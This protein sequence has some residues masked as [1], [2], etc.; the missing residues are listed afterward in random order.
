MRNF[1]K[2]YFSDLAL[3]SSDDEDYINE[4]KKD[5][6]SII[7]DIPIKD[8]YD[9]DISDD[10]TNI[11]QSCYNF[12][13]SK[14]NI[15]SKIIDYIH[16]KN[17]NN[18]AIDIIDGENLIGGPVIH[19]ASKV[20]RVFCKYL[21]DV[22]KIVIL[23]VKKSGGVKRFKNYTGIDVPNHFIFISLHADNGTCPDD[24]FILELAN[25]LSNVYVV[26]DDEY[27]DREN[28]NYGDIYNGTKLTTNI[29]INGRYYPDINTIN[30]T[31]VRRKGINKKNKQ[32][33]N[34]DIS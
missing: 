31:L 18:K 34:Y 20:K 11:D 24:G 2:C 32:I 26:T 12:D 23:V 13:Y 8:T 27:I 33:N 1:N 10:P 5:N 4:F 22:N 15:I 6:N 30:S 16:L 7:D 17:I 28:F 9:N 25:K 3:D 14:Q 21:N 29:G 19:R